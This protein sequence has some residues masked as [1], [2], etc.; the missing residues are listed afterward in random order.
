MKDGRRL[1]KYI[2]YDKNIHLGK[3]IDH[4][5]RE[6]YRF[7][8]FWT[9]STWQM[10]DKL[11]Y[12]KFLYWNDTKF[13]KNCWDKSFREIGDKYLANREVCLNNLGTTTTDIRKQ[14]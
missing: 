3:K 7:F 10:V 1:L 8:V 9:D 2:T 5:L 11:L 4:C 14:G 6:F 12:T 13:W